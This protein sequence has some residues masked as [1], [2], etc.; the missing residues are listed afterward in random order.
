MEFKSIN[1]NP[2][3]TPVIDE[4]IKAFNFEEKNHYYVREIK[5]KFEAVWGVEDRDDDYGSVGY[6]DID[7]QLVEN[8]VINSDVDFRLTPENK[9]FIET[10]IENASLYVTRYTLISE[11]QL[12][13]EYIFDA[14]K[15]NEALVE[16]VIESKNLVNADKVTM[17]LNDETVNNSQIT[18][19]ILKQS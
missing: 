4:I 16:F 2:K 7:W 8:G 18:F 1:I 10:H 11:Y 9:L 19:L 14:G 6:T 5:S 17:Y 15:E 12:T 13:V 3:T